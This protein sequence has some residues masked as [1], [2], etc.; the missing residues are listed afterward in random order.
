MS[1]GVQW[2]LALA[3]V[4]FGA[5]PKLGFSQAAWEY[6]PYRSRVWIAMER[7]PQVPASLVP[8]IADELPA[9]ARAAWG[10][11]MQIQVSAAPATMRSTLALRLDEITPDAVAAAAS[12]EDLEADKLYL[13]ALI[14]RD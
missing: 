13:A 9:R 14:F 2:L 3:I 12:R 4:F 5:T 11:V 6:T 8:F 1:R 7:V 10:E